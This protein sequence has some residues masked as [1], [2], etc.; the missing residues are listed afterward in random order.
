MNEY[1]IGSAARFPYVG[2]TKILA[3]RLF[4]PGLSLQLFASPENTTESHR[5]PCLVGVMR[6]QGHSKNP[7]PNGGDG[8]GAILAE[9]LTRLWHGHA[10][11]TDEIQ[12][13]VPDGGK[14]ACS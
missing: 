11:G 8:L 14:C 12:D 3:H 1:K 2:K 6:T 5:Q 13:K 4:P 7:A 9:I 10:A